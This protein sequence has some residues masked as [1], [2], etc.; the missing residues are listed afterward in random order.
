MDIE[1]RYTKHQ[2]QR[3]AHPDAVDRDKYILL[4]N[5]ST[6]HLTYQIRL[7]TYFALRDDKKLVIRVPR[8][9]ELA[10]SLNEFKERHKNTLRI[11]RV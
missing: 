11:E 2:V 4:K 9:C 8:S 7:M 3:G 6:L 10:K 1:P 5:V